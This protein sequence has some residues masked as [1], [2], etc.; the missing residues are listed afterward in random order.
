VP[1]AVAPER[2]DTF[3][4]TSPANSL[5]RTAVITPV[6]RATWLVSDAESYRPIRGWLTR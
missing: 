6:A 1:A 2:T 4:M 5:I 3:V